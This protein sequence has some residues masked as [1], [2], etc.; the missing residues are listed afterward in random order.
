MRRA[1][2]TVFSYPS[3]YENLILKP[4]KRTDFD[5]V[6]LVAEKFL[7]QVVYIGWPHLIKAKVVAIFN[8]EKYIDSDGFNDMIA[9]QFDSIVSGVSTQLSIF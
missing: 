7:N 2:I 4:V 1:G 3:R 8:R 6:I 9:A 5:N